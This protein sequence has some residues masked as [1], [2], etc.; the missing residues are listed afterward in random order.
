MISGF[1]LSAEDRGF[2]TRWGQTKTIKLV[3]V[4]SP[5]STQH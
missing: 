3:I 4:A 1:T 5:I 2:E